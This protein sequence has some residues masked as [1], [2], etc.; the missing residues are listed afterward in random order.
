ME[1]L[2]QDLQDIKNLAVLE[3]HSTN[4][5]ELP[6]LSKCHNLEVI[7]L[8]GSCLKKVPEIGYC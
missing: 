4:L 1:A 6:P 7:N 5:A 8:Q 3:I 2:P